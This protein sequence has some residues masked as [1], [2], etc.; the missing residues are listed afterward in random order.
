MCHMCR[1]LQHCAGDREEKGSSILLHIYRTDAL[2]GV[3]AC[4]R[5]EM[6]TVQNAGI[7]VWRKETWRE[8][9]TNST[10]FL[11]NFKNPVFGRTE[12]IAQERI[13]LANN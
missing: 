6:C 10:F 11:M 4:S 13:I 12:I 3:Q 7:T 5:V 2:A 9:K 8:K 1:M